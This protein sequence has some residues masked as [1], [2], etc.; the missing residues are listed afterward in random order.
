M[1]G[2][3]DILLYSVEPK[4][5]ETEVSLFSL[6]PSV[7][8]WVGSKDNDVH[9]LMTF[10]ELKFRMCTFTNPSTIS[11]VPQH[12]FLQSC[13]EHQMLVPFNIVPKSPGGQI[14]PGKCAMS[15]TAAKKT[16]CRIQGYLPNHHT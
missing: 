13:K 1:Q 2:R 5:N 4:T 15:V 8:I 12:R 3:V 11:F 10:T 14:D 16:T 7:N 6:R 9:T